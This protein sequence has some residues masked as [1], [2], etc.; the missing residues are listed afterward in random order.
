MIDLVS[1]GGGVMMFEWHVKYSTVTKNGTRVCCE[2]GGATIY[3][4]NEEEVRQIM[5]E[6]IPNAKIDSIAKGYEI[7]EKGDDS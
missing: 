2:F 4:E 5:E 7:P 1:K 3:A 6:E